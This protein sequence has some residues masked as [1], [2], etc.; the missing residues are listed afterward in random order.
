ME[1]L[2]VQFCKGCIDD[3]LCGEIEFTV[4]VCICE[5][6]VEECDNLE[7]NGQIDYNSRVSS[8]DTVSLE[9]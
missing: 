7:R 5:V 9:E 1:H 4:P 8:R 3:V 2:I 6:E